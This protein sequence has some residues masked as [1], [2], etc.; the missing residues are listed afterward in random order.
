VGNNYKIYKNKENIENKMVNGNAV[1]RSTRVEVFER[2]KHHSS[3]D[4]TNDR[5]VCLWAYDELGERPF[6]DRE[7]YLPDDSLLAS[8][9]RTIGE[10]TYADLALS[11]RVNEKVQDLLLNTFGPLR[12]PEDLK[13]EESE[14]FLR[15][16][17]EAYRDSSRYET[18]DGLEITAS[19]GT[20]YSE[21]RG[22]SKTFPVKIGF[23]ELVEG[24]PYQTS[25]SYKL[26]HYSGGGQT[27]GDEVHEKLTEM[28]ERLE[29][30]LVGAEMAV[31]G[32]ILKIEK[33]SKRDVVKAGK[34][35][36]RLLFKL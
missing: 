3:S 14:E 11:R 26:K 1:I 17:E 16:V 31:Q 32:R 5:A 30:M 20:G 21:D 25:F 27:P 8:T 12:Q 6:L 34:S 13:T 24:S 10:P 19:M 22:E 7:D 29:Q 35:V 18:F 4:L 23:S 9:C 28:K 36:Q 15:W 33:E 2:I